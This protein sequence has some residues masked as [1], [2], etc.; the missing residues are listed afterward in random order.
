M[1][2]HTSSYCFWRV[3]WLKSWN[4]R[5]AFI[6]FYCVLHIMWFITFITYTDYH[7]LSR[8][9]AGVMWPY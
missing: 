6:L 7:G 4:L 5:E 2:L 9:I 3:A 8:T 1:E